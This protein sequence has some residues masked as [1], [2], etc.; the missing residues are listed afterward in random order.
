MLVSQVSNGRCHR[1]I[2][3]L[4]SS[5]TSLDRGFLASY[6]LGMLEDIPC[7]CPMIKDLVRDIFVNWVLRGFLLLY[8]NSMVAQTFVAL[9]RV[10]TFSLPG[11]GGGNPFYKKETGLLATL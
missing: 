6:P 10:L 5:L 8:F 7:W 9:S 2:Q 4:T 11:I 3:V 1:S